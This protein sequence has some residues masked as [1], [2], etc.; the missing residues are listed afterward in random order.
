MESEPVHA[1]NNTPGQLPSLTVVPAGVLLVPGEI[2]DGTDAHKF[3][4]AAGLSCP[5]LEL[6]GAHREPLAPLNGRTN[7]CK[8]GA[9]DCLEGGSDQT[10]K[11]FA[12]WMLAVIPGNT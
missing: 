4:L 10:S 7:S 9:Y 8:E 11:A 3:R 2:S 5:L 12:P 6:Q 1:M